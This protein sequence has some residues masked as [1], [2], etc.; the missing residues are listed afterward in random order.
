MEF[1]AFED[2]STIFVTLFF[3]RPFK[4]FCQDLDM[5]HAYLL[6][7]LVESEFGAASLTVHHA[8]RIQ[9]NPTGAA[10][11]PPALR[12]GAGRKDRLT[13]QSNRDLSSCAIS[14]LRLLPPLLSL[15]RSGRKQLAFRLSAGIIY[16]LE[17][18]QKI[19]CC[20]LTFPRRT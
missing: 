13:P 7:G 3:P 1:F 9:T 17:F 19:I 16:P 4:R 10:Q 18:T 12:V 8:R 2:L 11:T 6:F 15:A 5:S 20:P 14:A